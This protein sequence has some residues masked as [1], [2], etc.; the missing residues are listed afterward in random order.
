MTYGQEE[1]LPRGLWAELFNAAAY[2][3]NRSGP[4]QEDNW[5]YELWFGK[6]PNIKHLRIIGST[7]YPHILKCN[8]KKMDKKVVKECLRNSVFRHFFSSIHG[9]KTPGPIA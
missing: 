9:T 5:P 7:S 6:K 3:I 4:T 1:T 2:M 8:R